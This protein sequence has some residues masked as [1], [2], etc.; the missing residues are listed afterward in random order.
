VITKFHGGAGS[1]RD[2]E[3]LVELLLYFIRPKPE[4]KLS[5]GQP[6]RVLAAP[7]SLLVVQG[8]V[9]V[10]NAEVWAHT[11][12]I[13]FK[14]YCRS[15]RRQ[16]RL[17]KRL[18]EHLV[19][20]FHPSDS[21]VLGFTP[22]ERGARAI[23]VAMDLVAASSL[24]E[25]PATFVAHGDRRSIHVHCAILGCNMKGKIWSSRSPAVFAE[26]KR[27]CREAEEGNG[28]YRVVPTG[29]VRSL[30][31]GEQRHE[32][33]TGV[34]APRA[35]LQQ[36]LSSILARRPSPAEFGEQCLEQAIL[37]VPKL[38][39]KGRISGI[40]YRLLD[41]DE[42]Y[43]FGMQRHFGGS[44]LGKRFVWGRVADAITYDDSKHR[45]IAEHWAL[46]AHSRLSAFRCVLRPAPS[47]FDASVDSAP[48]SRKKKK[49]PTEDRS[50]MAMPSEI[51]VME[52]R[53][54]SI[55]RAL[56]IA[57]QRGWNVLAAMQFR[58]LFEPLAAKLGIAIL[59]SRPD[60]GHAKDAEATARSRLGAVGPA[61]LMHPQQSQSTSPRGA[62]HRGPGAQ[63][64]PKPS[65]QLPALDENE[66]EDFEANKRSK[67]PR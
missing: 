26:L 5:A 25:C 34:P 16:K 20:S 56:A 15:A 60:H 17:P 3:A 52:P 4:M 8:G 55:R 35:V 64:V 13:S 7:V 19:I 37:V 14:L 44:D 29:E 31:A 65:P 49:Q 33:R 48:A 46:Q 10:L 9:S 53:P 24:H 50:V 28:L 47:P 41:G 32:A 21:R 6:E 22:R 43:G 30:S 18:F 67:R 45:P 66:P 51:I 2:I 57:A 62:H 59:P 39:A 27:L 42:T 11:L 23:A 61:P 1:A 12:A 36:R 63:V 40:S 58:H 38:N 54:K